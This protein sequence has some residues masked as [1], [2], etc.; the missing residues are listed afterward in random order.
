[1][2]YVARATLPEIATGPVEIA[3]PAPATQS[4]ETRVSKEAPVVLAPPVIL[5][6]PE[7]S[8]PGAETKV[9]VARAR[10]FMAQGDMTTARLFL[11]RASNLGDAQATYLLA[12]TY[13][14]VVLSRWKVLGVSPDVDKARALYSEAAAAGF[15]DATNRLSEFNRN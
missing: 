7:R 15:A 8:A 13:D 14:P 11:E 2:D 10:A 3:L 6:K 5:A 12:Q 4:R 1:M 9:F